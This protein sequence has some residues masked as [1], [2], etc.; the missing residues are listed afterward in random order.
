MKHSNTFVN[1]C[2]LMKRDEKE[3]NLLYHVNKQRKAAVN[4]RR[5]EP[6]HCVFVLVIKGVRPSKVY[7]S[8]SLKAECIAWV[9]RRRQ[10]H[11]VFRIKKIIALLKIVSSSCRQAVCQG[12]KKLHPPLRTY[13]TTHFARRHA[14]PLGYQS[15]PLNNTG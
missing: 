7:S 3:R 8:M 14:R 1:G 11:F 5:R 2:N 6:W 15:L 9:Q 13:F 12:L 10:G 4:R